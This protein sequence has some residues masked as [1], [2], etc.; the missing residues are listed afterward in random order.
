MCIVFLRVLEYYAGILFL[1]TNRVGDFD[2]AFASRIHISLYYPEL[3]DSKA[4]DVFL[5]NLNMI[6]QRFARR[7]REFKA[8]RAKIGAFCQRYWQEHPFDHWNGR[9]IRNACLTAV[10]L[11]EYEAQGTD[12][13]KIINPKA[14]VELKVSH[15]EEV[16]KAY[17]EFSEYI[18]DIY[19]THAA[20]RAKE[21][22]LRAMWVDNKGRLVGSIGPKESGILKTSR[23]DKFRR[24]AQGQG[25]SPYPEQQQQMHMP[26]RSGQRP[27]VH[28]YER[29]EV[30]HPYVSSRG[31]DEY[32][33]Y[34][35]HAGYKDDYQG[36]VDEG[37]HPRRDA[38]LRVPPGRQPP[39]PPHHSSDN[40]EYSASRDDYR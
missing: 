10:A 8:N 23:R 32:A 21:A 37:R 24:M 14:V 1:T 7:H 27:G 34:P 33:S 17:L 29:D 15:F 40:S 13:Y 36:D 28:G 31:H 3:D 4:L 11:A 35:Q 30:S 20:R 2:E 39:P 16:A 38:H 22:G 6:E 18:K 19:G 25:G 26:Y 5:V 12:P 9:Q